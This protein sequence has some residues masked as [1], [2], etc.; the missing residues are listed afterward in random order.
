[1]E[2]CKDTNISINVKLSLS[3]SL[4]FS[5][6]PATR[7]DVLKALQTRKFRAKESCSN[8]KLPAVAVQ[9]MRSCLDPAS[10]TERQLGRAMGGHGRPWGPWELLVLPLAKQS[11]TG[12]HAAPFHLF[13]LERIP[14]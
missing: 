8:S 1:M 4:P 5:L 11:L 2:T 10:A 6:L 9:A 13:A 7:A 12:G 3:L 14:R